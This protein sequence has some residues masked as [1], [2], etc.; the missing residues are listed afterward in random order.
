MGKS[1]VSSMC[2]RTPTRTRR[3]QFIR[4]TTQNKIAIAHQLF[5]YY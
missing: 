5:D 4:S 1:R 2:D 3:A